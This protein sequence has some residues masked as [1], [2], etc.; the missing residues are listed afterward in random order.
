M[1]SAGWVSDKLFGARRGPI[2][3]IFMAGLSLTML[4]FWRADTLPKYALALP[5]AGSWSTD[6]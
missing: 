2:M 5:G 3:G 1:L 6:R 4:A